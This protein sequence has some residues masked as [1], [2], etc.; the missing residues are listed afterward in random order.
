MN[1]KLLLIGVLSVTLTRATQRGVWKL[2]DANGLLE[3]YRLIGT[4]FIE[5]KCCIKWDKTWTTACENLNRIFLHVLRDQFNLEADLYL[6][7]MGVWSDLEKTKG[8]QGLCHVMAIDNEGSI[9][10]TQS[11]RN[12]PSI[13]KNNDESNDWISQDG[14]ILGSFVGKIK[15]A[16]LA[17]GKKTR[18]Q[19][20]MVGEILSGFRACVA[21]QRAA[22]HA[23][24][25]LTLGLDY[26]E[27]RG[28]KK[29]PIHVRRLAP[30]TLIDVEQKL[31]KY[32]IDKLRERYPKGAKR[33]AKASPLNM[34]KLIA[35]LLLIGD[36]LEKKRVT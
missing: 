13:R 28:A 11:V 14:Y 17:D 25:D 30:Q 20:A 7:S 10:C 12:P 22:D 35:R 3:I 15:D 31:Y 36:T 4:G 6:L 32:V 2:T 1:Y 29:F 19:N 24:P 5:L 26:F 34:E 33:S 9:L 8:Y 16:R 18:D 27:V 23:P 21:N